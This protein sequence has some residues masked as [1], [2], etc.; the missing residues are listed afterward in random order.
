MRDMIKNIKVIAGIK[1]VIGIS[2]LIDILCIFHIWAACRGLI[3]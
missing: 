2:M 3:I 1:A